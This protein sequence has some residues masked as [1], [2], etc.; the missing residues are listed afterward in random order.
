[1]T[2]FKL[3]SGVQDLLPEECYNLNIIK[4]K[5]ER[6]FTLAGCKFV[7]S[8]AIE[9][10][11]TFARIKNSIPQE[12]MFKMTDSDGKLLVLRPD[13]TLAAARIAATKLKNTNVKLCYVSDVWKFSAAA[14]ASRRE[15][16][17]AGVESFGVSSPLSDAQMIA[18]SIEC[19]KE[20]GIKEFIV[21]I[22]HVGFFK[23][24]LSASMLTE[25]ETEEIRKGVNAKDG[26]GVQMILKN[27]KAER[28]AADAIMALPTLFGGEEVFA[29]AEKFTDNAQALN[30]LAHLKKVYD[31][32]KSFGLEKYISVDLGTVKSLAYYSG[33]VFTGYAKNFGSDILSGGRYD[34]LADEFG[35]HIPAVGFAMGLKRALMALERQGDLA[36]QGEP[37]VLLYCEEGA[38]AVAYSAYRKMTEEGKIVCLQAESLS[39]EEILKNQGRGRIY[40]A[41]KGGIV[42]L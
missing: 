42:E 6:K 29:R 1:M 7:S 8:A 25:E 27:S 37:D 33:V 4:R 38:E 21:D 39:D 11:D 28:R 15:F 20:T 9:Y 17:Q 24:L 16:L 14:G 5:L 26:I 41:T 10:Y 18:F 12:K 3:P 36:R 35:K 34:N 19:L 22:G 30:A 32:L 23:G 40:K 13:M 31:L 2:Y